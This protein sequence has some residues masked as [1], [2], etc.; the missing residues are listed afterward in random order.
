MSEI[1]ADIPANLIVG[2]GLAKR[3]VIEHLLSSKASGERW[4]VLDNDTTALAQPA[5][6]TVDTLSGRCICCADVGL[7]VALTRLLRATRP[8]RLLLLPSVRARI[9]EVLRL[10]SDRWL[11]P[12]LELRATIAVL[13]AAYP[14]MTATD[15]GREALGHVQI[16]ALEVQG[17]TESRIDNARATLAGVAPQ[18]KVVLIRDGDLDA[19]LLEEAGAPVRPRFASR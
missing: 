17:A 7:R 1:L 11:A 15:D 4:A 8:R 6:D 9:P 3:R 13:D 10:L 19:R 2:A 14:G 16:I 12:V 18:A 5:V